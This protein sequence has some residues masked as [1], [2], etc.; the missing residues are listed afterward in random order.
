[1]AHLLTR[2]K[3]SSKMN[4][5]LIPILRTKDAHDS[6]KWYR[7]LGFEIEGEHQFEPDLPSYLFLARGTSRLH[8]SEHEGDAKPGTLLYFYVQDV[9]S[10]AMEFAAEVIEQPWAREVH[11]TDPDG[12]RLRI[13]E[14][15]A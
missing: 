11:L 7:R 14:C 4:E 6:A 5:E 13:G 2:E 9:G 1:M 12:N 15:K 3:V 8:L 10:I